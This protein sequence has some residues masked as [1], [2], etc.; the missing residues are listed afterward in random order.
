VRDDGDR[1]H[2]VYHRALRQIDGL[3]ARIVVVGELSGNAVDADVQTQTP[4][5]DLRGGC[6]GLSRRGSHGGV[7]REGAFER[8]LRPKAEQEPRQREREIEHVRGRKTEH[9]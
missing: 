9:D 8:D 2:R 6:T 4:D 3:G 1:R 7:A 5:E